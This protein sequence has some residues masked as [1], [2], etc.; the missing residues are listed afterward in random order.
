MKKILY[1]LLVLSTICLSQDFKKTATAGFTFLELPVS[2]RVA[3]L[4]ESSVALHDLN[5]SAVFT[6]P[7]ALGFTSR[8]HSFSASYS[9]WFA[10]I[11]NYAS[12]YSYKSD[13]GVLAVG[14]V[15]VD[16]GS[17][18]R[19]EIASGTQVYN[20]IGSF[21][22]SSIAVGL[23]YSKQLT[24]KF[25][26]GV[27]LKYVQEKIDVYDATNVLFDGGVIYYTGLQ[28][29]RIAA[30]IQHFGVDS[31]F[32]NDEFKMPAMLRLGA[33]MEVLGSYES[34][35]RLTVICEALH[36]T[37]NDERVNLGA[38]LGWKNLLVLRGGY[39][40]FYDEESFSFGVGITPNFGLPITFDY[41]FAD[42]GR[43]GNISRFTVQMGI[44]Q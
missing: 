34:E 38:E 18:P 21:D 25:S 32:I 12:S 6:N 28:S 15:M 29:L 14:F 2:A 36:Y 27:T 10:D 23:S 39:K 3:A 1:I 20:V 24:D 40:F 5:S 30:S 17:M 11:K 41:A 33:A 31:K 4:G 13:L 22:A 26:F 8:Q 42:Y 44:D 35:Y 7:G 9:P 19:T 37:D 43:L 16:Y